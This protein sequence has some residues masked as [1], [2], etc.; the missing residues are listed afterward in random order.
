MRT[1]TFKPRTLIACAAVSCVLAACGGDDGGGGGSGGGL[2]PDGG[3]QR[4]TVPISQTVL[5]DGTTRYSIP[6]TI[7]NAPP[8]NAMLDTGS[9]GLRVL[10]GAVPASAYTASAT[11]TSYAYGAGVSLI[12][13]NAT[14][15]L[16]LGSLPSAAPVPMMAI[17]SLACM[18]ANPHCPASKMSIDEY[19]I[20]GDGLPNEG[21]KAI[22][23]VA[24]GFQAP[25]QGEGVPSPLPYFGQGQFIVSLP[26]PG[27][28][29]GT[30]TINPTADDLKGFTMYAL[31]QLP[32]A[33]PNGV[34]AWN[35]RQLPGCLANTATGKS[36]CAPTMLDSGTGSV[37]VGGTASEPAPPFAANDA[38]V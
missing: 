3:P 17:S 1:T 15:N 29:T 26:A 6:V 33:L 8:V 28:A 21:F 14:A 7:G 11:T 32:T 4:A 2:K 16:T 19:G 25:A 38:A 37:V 13:N 27:Q 12:G 24:L 35:V 10:P 30:L 5:S 36:F 20:G 9:W 22:I 18:P 31:K 23:G 34:P